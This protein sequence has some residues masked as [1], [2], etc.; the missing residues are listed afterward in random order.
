MFVSDWM[1]KKVY[2]IGVDDSISDAIMIMKEKG[3]KHLPVLKDDKLKGII[4]DGDIKEF[5]P[6]KAT[7]LDIYELH[8]LLAVTKVKEAMKVKVFTTTPETPVEEAAMVMHDE[9]IGCLPVLDQGRL[10]G[11]ISDRDIYRVLVDITGVRHGGH[12]IY[13]TIEDRP[14]SVKEVADIIRKHAFHLQ[15]ILTSYEGV[16]EGYRDLVIR[17][18]GAG[19]FRKLKAELEGTY[20]NVKIKK[21]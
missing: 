16:K 1:T 21:G 5:S 15:S 13:V 7:S 17:A 4:S 12:R 8:Y 9:N 6:S 19:D 11:I 10:V 20:R 18:K 2:T 3:I 14:G